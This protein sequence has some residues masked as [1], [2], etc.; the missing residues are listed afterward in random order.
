MY[1]AASHKNLT[2][3]HTLVGRVC[4]KT[5][6]R[7]NIEAVAECVGQIYRMPRTVSRT[8]KKHT[9]NDKLLGDFGLSA[10]VFHC[11]RSIIALL[12]LV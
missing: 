5:E 3:V 9:Y 10:S 4:Q 6:I 11:R 7:R 1:H 12:F 8:E 2:R